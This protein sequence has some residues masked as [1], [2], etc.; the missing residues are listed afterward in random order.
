MVTEWH[1]LLGCSLILKF[2]QL[3]K[4]GIFLRV[5]LIDKTFLKELVLSVFI[6]LSLNTSV[7]NFFFTD[8]INYKKDL[9]YAFQ[10]KIVYGLVGAVRASD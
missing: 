1:K 8:C 7:T 5:L 3:L 6:E 2:L 9:A 4:L 10:T